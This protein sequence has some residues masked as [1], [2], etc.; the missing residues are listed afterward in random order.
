MA[1]RGSRS[2]GV[3]A[4][5]HDL[6]A[7][8]AD[9]ERRARVFSALGDPTR[10]ALVDLL[11]LGDLSP[12]ALAMALG[13]SGN[14][15]AHHLKVLQGAGLVTRTDSQHDRRRTYVHLDEGAL[16]DLLPPSREIVTRRIVFVCTKNS[17]RS[18][19]AGALWRTASDVPSTS[20]GT[21][22]A[23]AVNPQAR[24]AARRAGIKLAQDAPQDV[25]AVLREDDLVVSVCD[26]VNEELTGLRQRH[27]HWS[28]PDPVAVGSDEAFDAALA[29][30]HGRVRDLAPLVRLG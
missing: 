9:R 29:D 8:A 11:R 3:V 26:S 18:I 30:L 28:V 25:S 1:D 21:R 7:G 20:A 5:L 4:P 17:A 15:L 16:G 12:D 19:L 2:R 22:P 27:L 14:L 10:L 13:V 24:A 23:E 6:A